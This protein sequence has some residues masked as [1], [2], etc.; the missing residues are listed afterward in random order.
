[1][2]LYVEFADIHGA[3]GDAMLGFSTLTNRRRIK[4]IKLTEEQIKQLQPRKIKESADTKDDLFEVVS[5]LC[6]SVLQLKREY[7][8]IK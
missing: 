2:Y 1:M 3:Y 5:V 8:K 4:R 6:I 7:Q